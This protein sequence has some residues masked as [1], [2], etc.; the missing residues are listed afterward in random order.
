MEK[1]I[2]YFY[3]DE[4]QTTLDNLTYKTLNRSG[5]ANGFLFDI[6]PRILEYLEIPKPKEMTGLSLTKNII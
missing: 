2:N 3:P 4:M 6:A 5:K 1:L